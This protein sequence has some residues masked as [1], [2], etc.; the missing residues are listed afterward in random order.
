MNENATRNGVIMI[1]L[2]IVFGIAGVL[3]LKFGGSD[4]WPF[5]YYG[6]SGHSARLL[7]GL[8]GINIMLGSMMYFGS[9]AEV[10]STRSTSVAA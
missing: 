3:L 2:G 6:S 4:G 9:Q 7:L 1:A 10:E 5:D 8:C